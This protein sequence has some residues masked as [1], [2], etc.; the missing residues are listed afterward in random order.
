MHVTDQLEVL[1]VPVQ[2]TGLVAEVLAL[3]L[4][5][6]G[7]RARV[8]SDRDEIPEPTADVVAVEASAPSSDVAATCARIRELLPGVPVVL[9]ME[10]PAADP[11]G[12]A[13][14]TGAD[15]CV[16]R[17]EPL[18][19]VAESLAAAA[20]GA[21]RRVIDLRR[22]QQ[23]AG[24]DPP[25]LTQRERQVLALISSGARSDDVALRLNISPHTVRTHVQN[26]L[27]KLGVTNRLSAAVVARQWGLLGPAHEVDGVAGHAGR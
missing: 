17:N 19:D 22:A 4:Q 26:V 13:A 21:P 7:L 25:K 2:R 6:H 24:E 27:V 16:Y 11:V 5:A 3:G 1:L 15:G 10:K 14:A 9:L 18:H 12:L 20:R 8:G 23:N